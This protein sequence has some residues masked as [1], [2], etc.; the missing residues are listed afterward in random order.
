MFHL[1]PRKFSWPFKIEYGLFGNLDST[2]VVSRLNPYFCISYGIKFS[3]SLTIL[4]LYW[5]KMFCFTLTTFQAPSQNCLK[6]LLESSRLCVW[7]S[8]YREQLGSHLMA[9]HGIGIWVFFENLRKSCRLW[10]NV[11]K[12]VTARQATDNNKIG[13]W[14][15]RFFCWITKATDTDAEYAILVALQS[16]QWLGERASMLH[17]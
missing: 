13:I 10:D 4:P 16:Q 9:F 11:E 14:R 12:Y 6:R 7:P 15:M 2:Q 1:R 3:F 8:V 5:M 17:L